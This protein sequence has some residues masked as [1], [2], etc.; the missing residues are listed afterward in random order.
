M[1][2]ELRTKQIAEAKERLQILVDR[3]LLPQVKEDFEKD[4]TVY[5]SFNSILYWLIPNNNCGKL[6]DAYKTFE[7]KNNI[8]VYAAIH[9]HTEFG[10][11]LTM[12]YVSAHEQEWELDREELIND[13]PLAYVKN[14]T[15]PELSE[16][17][18]V[19][20]KTQDG[21]LIRIA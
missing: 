12:L 8:L 10:E 19:G 16:F 13:F 15:Y 9:S 20:V 17:G 5:Y 11:L 2:N 1:N 14:L 3:E 18:I 7:H 4:G 6:Y 21:G